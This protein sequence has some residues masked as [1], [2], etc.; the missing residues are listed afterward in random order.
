MVGR[1][2]PKLGIDRLKNHFKVRRKR[3]DVS[4]SLPDPTAKNRKR[5]LFRR[6]WAKR[7]WKAL[8]AKL[9]NRL[10][11]P[12]RQVVRTSV[13]VADH[14]HRQ[15]I[16]NSEGNE[17]ISSCAKDETSLSSSA[18]SQGPQQESVPVSPFAS[19]CLYR[20][21]SQTQ[22][23]TRL[24]LALVRPPCSPSSPE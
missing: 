10:R 9:R 7:K 8:L 18:P 3:S 13:S 17:N 23:P 11:L 5:E 4:L 22:F 1:H 2:L 19:S 15:A 20:T 14:R 21:E 16:F 12:L 24:P 6:F